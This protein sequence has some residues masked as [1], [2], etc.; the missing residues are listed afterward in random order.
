MICDHNLDDYAW[1]EVG[2]QRF[3]NKIEAVFAHHK[4]RQPIRWNVTD[5]D[6][7]QH[8]WDVE[9]LESLETLYAQRAQ[10]IRNRY[11]HLVLHFSGGSDSANILET[12]IRNKIHLDE[13]IIRGSISQS[14]ENSG[15]L[16]DADMYAEC[17]SQAIPLANWVKE[18]HMPHLRITIVDTVDI[19]NSFYKNNPDWIEQGVT[20]LTPS[21]YLKNNVGVL[22]PHYLQ[23]A[24]QGKKVGHII[25]IEKPDIFQDKNYFYTRYLDTVRSDWIGEQYNTNLG[26]QYIEL[27]YWGKNAIKLQIKQLHTIKQHIKQNLPPNWMVNRATGRAW[28]N[29]ISSIIYNRTLPLLTEHIKDTGRSLIAARDQWFAKDIHNNSYTNWYKGADYIRSAIPTE[30]HHD[31]G[32]W[33]SGLKGMW[34]KPYYLGT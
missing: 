18:N 24:E 25:G 33:T 30:W 10:H 20:K 22:S 13:V 7:G 21:N 3:Y 19:I 17:K 32:F 28:E 14:S 15:V 4:T 31:N 11:D 12:F 23:L 1:Y 29:F 16:T 2:S 26:P 6:Y 9:P 8:K 27:F 5:S 34:S